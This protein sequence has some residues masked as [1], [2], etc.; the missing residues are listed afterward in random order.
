MAI[1]V[2]QTA[3]QNVLDLIYGQ[4]FRYIF[5]RSQKRKTA[6]CPH[7][8]TVVIF[9]TDEDVLEKLQD[10]LEEEGIEWNR[11]DAADWN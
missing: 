4:G 5:S 11:V 2:N 6:Q 1:A 7:I 10:M 8:G 9:D 3:E